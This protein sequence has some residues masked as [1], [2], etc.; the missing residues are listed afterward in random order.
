[1]L[2]EC[3][4][5]Q[6]LF[7]ILFKNQ[8]KYDKLMKFI[9]IMSNHNLSIQSIKQEPASFDLI[10]CKENKEIFKLNVYETLWAATSNYWSIGKKD[11]SVDQFANEI[12]DHSKFFI[13]EYLYDSMRAESFVINNEEKICIVTDKDDDIVRTYIDGKLVY[14]LLKVFNE[15]KILIES[16]ILECGQTRTEY[17]DSMKMGSYILDKKFPLCS[18]L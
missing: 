9:S 16:H 14:F 17:C 13:K 4:E 2:I 5:L 15:D 11:K 12:I 8:Q 7:N 6:Q 10:F 1:M 3:N 18:K